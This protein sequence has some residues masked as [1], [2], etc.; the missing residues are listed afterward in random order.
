MRTSLQAQTLDLLL[1]CNRA[2]S[3]WTYSYFPSGQIFTS[4]FVSV[5]RRAALLPATHSHSHF[6]YSFCEFLSAMGT[7]IISGGCFLEAISRGVVSSCWW[8]LANRR[9][10]TQCSLS[11]I[12]FLKD[13]PL[14]ILTRLLP[15]L[16]SLKK[17]LVKLHQLCSDIISA[18]GVRGLQTTEAL[19]GQWYTH[20]IC[21]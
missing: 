13:V 6:S 4:S 7:F 5:S 10:Q 3:P 14:R 17:S 19:K 18:D 2:V 8:M 1:I 21:I 11:F 9:C 20:Q 15:P 12:T 16:H